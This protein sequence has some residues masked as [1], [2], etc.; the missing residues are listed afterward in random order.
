MKYEAVD[1]SLHKAVSCG[2]SNGFPNALDLEIFL[3]GLWRPMASVIDAYHD[4]V[5]ELKN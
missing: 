3:D 4:L 1:S 5:L 2:R